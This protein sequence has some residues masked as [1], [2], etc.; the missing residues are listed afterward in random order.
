LPYQKKN[1]L[2]LFLELPNGIPVLK[3]YKRV[4]AALDNQCI[5]NCI[6]A[7]IYSFTA[8]NN[9][10]V[11]AINGTYIKGEKSHDKKLTFI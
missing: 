5:K 11:L 6:I 2:E 3:T 7:L 4:F 1:F 8:L 9:K 10:A